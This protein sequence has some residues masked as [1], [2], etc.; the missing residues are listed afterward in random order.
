LWMYLIRLVQ[1]DGADWQWPSFILFV[2]LP[3]D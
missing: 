2:S 3:T 1:L